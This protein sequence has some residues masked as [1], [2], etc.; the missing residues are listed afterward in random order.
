MTT[1]EKVYMDAQAA[2][3]L[4]VGDY[5]QVLGKAESHECGWQNYWRLEKTACIEKV[6]KIKII[7]DNG[8]GISFDRETDDYFYFPYFVL[9]K[10]E[11]PKYEFKPFDR[12][13]VRQE[14][15]EIWLCE[16]FSFFDKDQPGGAVH[17]CLGG[18]YRY[19]I[20]YEGNEHL[21]GTT[22]TPEN[23]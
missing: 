5:V 13:L 19:C 17:I 9:E 6:G 2:C 8:I 14:E 11:K 15:R 20:P 10:V 1:M 18:I 22:K 21:V 4:K 3:G 23:N 16:F 7:N 12:V